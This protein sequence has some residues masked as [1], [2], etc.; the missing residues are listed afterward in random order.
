M[1][2]R[3]LIPRVSKN[4]FHV[5]QALALCLHEFKAALVKI[6]HRG[7]GFGEK[8]Y[9]HRHRKNDAGEDTGRTQGISSL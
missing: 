4:I 3:D 9:G 7:D 5:R 1:M 6:Q 2:M 8:K